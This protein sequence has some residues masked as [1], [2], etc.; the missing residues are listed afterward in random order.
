MTTREV[1]E[2]LGVLQE[3]AVVVL[4]KVA[5]GV[6]VGI[7]HKWTDGEIE[8]VREYLRKGEGE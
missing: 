3:T 8:L 4:R 5:P 6:T 7:N 2:K 1:A